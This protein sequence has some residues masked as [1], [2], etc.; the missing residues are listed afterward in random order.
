MFPF[1]ECLDWQ[2]DK[3]SQIRSALGWDPIRRCKR[4]IICESDGIQSRKTLASAVAI[5]LRALK[6][7]GAHVLTF[8]D[9][10]AGRDAKWMAPIFQFLG[11]T[12]GHVGQHTSKQDR[13]IAYGCDITYVTAKEAGFDFLRDQLCQAPNDRVHPGFHFAI[14]DEADSI[15]IDEARVPMVIA[16]DDEKDGTDL[17][18]NAKLVRPLQEGVDYEVKSSGRNIRQAKSRDF[19]ASGV[20]R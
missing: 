12:V 19:F 6:G 9:Y 5:S 10:L 2:L 4:S 20:S 7:Q 13:Q 1:F 14:A 11:L 15:L 17:Y 3:K 18:H 16:T 8:N